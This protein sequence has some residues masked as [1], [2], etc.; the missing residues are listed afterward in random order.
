M[1]FNIKYIKYIDYIMHCVR[2]AV[3]FA[4][5]FRYLKVKNFFPK[6][7]MD[8]NINGR[9]FKGSIV[10]LKLFYMDITSVRDCN[11]NDV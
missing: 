11:I 10:S 2:C 4:L 5:K 7:V 8:K 9:H 6:N 1:T 3:M